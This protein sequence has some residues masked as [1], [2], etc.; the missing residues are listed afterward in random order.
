MSRLPLV[1][2]AIPFFNNERT[3]TDAIRSV[4]AQSFDDWELLLVNDGSTDRSLEI[5]ERVTDRRVRIIHD[6]Q[7]RGLIYRLNQ[8]AAMARGRYLARMDADDMMLPDRLARQVEFLLQY[9]DTDLVDTGAFTMDTDGRPVG[10]R[11]IE[12]I[13]TDDREVLRHALLLHASVVGKTE[14][15]RRHPYDSRYV[16]A[17]DYE[18]WLRTYRQSVFRRIPEYLYV[19]REGKVNVRNYA[20]SMKTLRRIFRVYGRG[21]L[22]APALQWEIGKTYLKTFAYY[23]MAAFGRQDM[24]TAMRNTPLTEPEKTRLSDA[25]EA[26]RAYQLVNGERGSNV[27]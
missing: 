2:I 5:A 16:R 19:I 23:T 7:N 1:T 24:L 12:P 4:L 27:E 3:L 17:E 20:A 15:F 26:I 11:G 6:G 8:I 25:L 9:P 22:T 10:K 18:L 21:V 14:W 13:R